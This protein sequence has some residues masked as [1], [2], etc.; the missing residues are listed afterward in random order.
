MP[1][2]SE[3]EAQERFEELLNRVAAGEAVTITRDGLEIATIVP[4]WRKRATSPDQ[5]P[6]SDTES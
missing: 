1:S 5:D 2:Y 4:K 6:A 3:A